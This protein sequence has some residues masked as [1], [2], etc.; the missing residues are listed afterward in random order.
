M[1]RHHIRADL[2]AAFE[3]PTEITDAAEAT[4]YQ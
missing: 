3:L 2:L 4:E 1:Q